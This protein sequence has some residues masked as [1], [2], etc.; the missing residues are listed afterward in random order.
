MHTGA[1]LL[2]T[3]RPCETFF[4]NTSPDIYVVHFGAVRL[5][6]SG[7][8]ELFL[9]HVARMPPDIDVVHVGAVLHQRSGLFE[10]LLAQI[11]RM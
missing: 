1:L 5:Q 3:L 7:L 10:L 8:F 4:W 2:Q 11:V 9:A 6:M